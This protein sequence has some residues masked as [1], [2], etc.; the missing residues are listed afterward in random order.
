MRV[1][2]LQSLVREHEG[3]RGGR[4]DSAAMGVR[5]LMWV[6]IARRWWFC[7]NEVGSARWVRMGV[8]S[9]F[10]VDFALDFVL[11]DEALKSLGSLSFEE[12][13]L[14][15]A[16]VLGGVLD[17]GFVPEVAGAAV[18]GPDSVCGFDQGRFTQPAG[19]P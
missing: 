4:L 11:A 2:V 17:C 6:G 7:G 9:G 1:L 5:A 15:I 16:D 14:L 19:C 12:L 18:F 10:G 13:L 8:F 3:E